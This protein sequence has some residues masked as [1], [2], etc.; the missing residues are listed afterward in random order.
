MYVVGWIVACALALLVV[1]A[2]RGRIALLS[3]GYWRFLLAPWKLVTAAT[4]T[5]AITLVAPHSG[6]PTWDTTDSLLISFLVFTTAPYAVAT[7]ARAWRRRVDLAESY[8]ALCTWGL[9]ASWTYDAYIWWRDGVYPASWDA[10][11]V[12]SSVIYAAAGLLWNLDWRPGQGA[13]FAFAAP[14]WPVAPHPRAWRRLVWI[15]LPFVL[16][17]AGLVL[18]FLVPAW[19]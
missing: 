4:A 6:D 10:N 7:L 17:V 13:G 15:M 2:R 12:L 18:A 16:L 11:L 1:A 3:R 5:A 8:V 9:A 19:Q 14:D